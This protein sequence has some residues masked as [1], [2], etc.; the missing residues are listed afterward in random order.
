VKPLSLPPNQFH[1]FY[2]GGARIAELRGVRHHDDHAPEDWVGSVTTTF[3]SDEQGLS[4]LQD[5]RLLAEAIASDPTSFL[6]PAHVE[7]RGSD[8]ALLVKLLDAG[9]RLPVHFHPDRRFARDRLGSRYGKTEAW[10]VVAADGDE[11]AVHL[12]LRD[13][14]DADTLGGWVVRQEI[15]KLLGA[16]NRVSVAAG[17]TFFVPAGLLHVIGD[18]LLIVELQEPSDLSV[19]LEWQGFKL[20]GPAEGHLGLGFDSALS[21]ASFDRLPPDRL[22]ALRGRRGAEGG[23][24]DRL[25]PAEADAFFRAQRIRP[26]PSCTLDREFSIV[27][28]L[29]GVGRLSSEGG[30]M[31]LARGDTVLVPWAAGETSIEGEL[32]AV[33]CLPPEVRA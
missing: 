5:G 13:A 7:S 9:E 16:L 25:F 8:T 32:E 31:A 10:V 2:R 15:P 19:L 4:R 18:G 1:R 21:A 30:S 29:E 3:G 33:R 11:P 14:V 22:E 27:V 23:G 12:G 26:K 28:V 24:I 17:D 6:G 20:D